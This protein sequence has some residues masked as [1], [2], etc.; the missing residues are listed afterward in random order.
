MEVNKTYL[1]LLIQL[2]NKDKNVNIDSYQ[3]ELTINLYLTLLSL[4]NLPYSK[5]MEELER[6]TI[7]DF[8]RKLNN[9]KVKIQ[10]KRKDE[11][12]DKFISSLINQYYENV[13]ILSLYIND[14]LELENTINEKKPQ[15][16]TTL[17]DKVT[18]DK[19]NKEDRIED[20]N[21]L[22]DNLTKI[23]PISKYYI[24]EGIISIEKDDTYIEIS[25]KEFL[26]MYSYLLNLNNYQKIYP[27]NQ[28]QISHDLI[29]ANIIKLLIIKDKTQEELNKVIIPLVLTHILTL[30]IDETFNL[31]TSYFNIENIKI[32]ELYS[33]A[34]KEQSEEKNIKWRNISIPNEYVISKLKDMVAKGMYYIK[35]ENFVFENIENKTSDFKISINI[36][37]IKRFLTEILETAN[38]KQ[39]ENSTKSSNI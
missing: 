37:R 26:E 38:N 11:E 25:I 32:T 13:N 23:F 2:L 10:L 34:N 17:I 12:I 35:E 22:R 1:E 8:L 7:N 14:T 20:I 28:N 5:K 33:L 16:L 24:H 30:D 6:E 31:D 15:N 36:E 39:K 4:S 29:I 27:N 3:E 19:M 18:K 21:L 9:L